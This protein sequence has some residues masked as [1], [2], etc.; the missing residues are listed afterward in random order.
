MMMIICFL[1]TVPDHATG[2][3]AKRVA[4]M[5]LESEVVDSDPNNKKKLKCQ[6]CDKVREILFLTFC[7]IVM[8]TQSTA[9][10]FFAAFC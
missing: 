7:S 6:Y 10:E 9:L 5:K 3:M 8:N 1:A 4:R 2:S